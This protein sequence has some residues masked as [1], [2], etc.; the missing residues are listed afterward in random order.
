MLYVNASKG[1]KAGGFPTVP[2]LV[3]SEFSPVHQES[4]LAYEG[5]FKTT[6]LERTLQFDGAVYYYDY[7]N[8]QFTGTENDPVFGPLPNLI[9]VPKSHVLGF[10][11]SAIWQP[12]RGLTIT[13]SISDADSRID[14]HPIF[15]T[16]LGAIVDTGGEKFP[17]APQ[18]QGRLDAEYDWTLLD[19]MK[20]FVGGAATYTSSTNDGLGEAGQLNVPSRALVD[21]RAGAERGAWRAELWGKNV[22]N[23]YYWVQSI[24]LA[25]VVARTTG[26]PAIF[27]VTVSYRYH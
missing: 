27:G 20:A 23:H 11:L 22:T 9:N 5:G 6:L 1:Y 16:P 10:E 2:A 17:F 4:V 12:M 13:P 15:A 24:A 21:L 8:K 19:N 25:N 7:T 14:G 26:M 3:A 18:W